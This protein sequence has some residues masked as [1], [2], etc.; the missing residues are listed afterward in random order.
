MKDTVGRIAADGCLRHISELFQI[1]PVN[2]G[3][4]VDGADSPYDFLRRA[5]GSHVGTA[6]QMLRN[7]E[8]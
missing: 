2:P 7:I 6:F 3:F 1:T 8:S 5:S 4:L